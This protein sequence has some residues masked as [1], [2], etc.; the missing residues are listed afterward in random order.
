[1][2]TPFP[3]TTFPSLESLNSLLSSITLAIDDF[4]PG[5]KRREHDLEASKLLLEE[6]DFGG[7]VND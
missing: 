5:A 1:M 3:D 4:A 6:E 2:T 7:A